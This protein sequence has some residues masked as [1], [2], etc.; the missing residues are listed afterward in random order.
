MVNKNKIILFLIF[1]ILLFSCQK[2]PMDTVIN[3]KNIK[4]IMHKISKLSRKK[5]VEVMTI[6]TEK[7]FESTFESNKNLKYTDL[8]KSKL[9]GKTMN[10][11]IEE[12]GNNLKKYM[13]SLFENK[14]S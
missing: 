3:D 5:Q 6:I 9:Y 1:I 12:S 11:L 2:N 13:N 10:Q 7:S 4:T 8:L 14:K